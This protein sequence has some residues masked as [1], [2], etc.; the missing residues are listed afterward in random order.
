MK[1]LLRVV[2]YLWGVAVIFGITSVQAQPTTQP[3]ALV[4]YDAPAGTE[5]E[6][7]GLA[8]SIMLKNLLGHF[9]AQVEMVPPHGCSA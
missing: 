3:K 6:K 1:H 7:L 2:A 9:N 5:F 4:L 8:Y